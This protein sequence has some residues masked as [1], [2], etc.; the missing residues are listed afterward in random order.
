MK[1][2]AD[3]HAAEDKKRREVIELKNQAEHVIYQTEKN[4]KEFGE[5]VS[6]EVRSNI[7]SAMNS[8]RD[9]V[10][11]E[12]G[13]RIKKG[14]E[15]LNQASM[16]LGEEMYK[17]TAAGTDRGGV[18][19]AAAAAAGVAGAAGAAGAAGTKKDDDV[20]DAEFEVKE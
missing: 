9:A 7:E 15:N 3:A 1:S 8:L 14:L 12:D 17:A 4:L 11:A 20:I 10:K 18:D 6:A 13:E 16:K 2:E 19:P 5:K